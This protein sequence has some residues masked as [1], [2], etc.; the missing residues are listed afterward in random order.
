M[1]KSKNIAPNKYNAYLID[2]GNASCCYIF[3]KHYEQTTLYVFNEL[4]LEAEEKIQKMNICKGD[5]L[6]ILECN[7]LILETACI[8]ACTHLGI[9]YDINNIA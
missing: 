8:L 5:T 9:F 7:N 4:I 3:D 6:I 1:K 2:K